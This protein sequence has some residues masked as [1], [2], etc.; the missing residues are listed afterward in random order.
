MSGYQIPDLK[1]SS[2]QTAMFL[3]PYGILDNFN[4]KDHSVLWTFYFDATAGQTQLSTFSIL[5]MLTVYLFLLFSAYKLV[6]QK[7][8]DS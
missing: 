5:S 4:H 3:T 6:I 1:D 7:G 2:W 8:Q